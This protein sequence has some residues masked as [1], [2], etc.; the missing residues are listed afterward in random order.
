MRVKELMTRRN[1]GTKAYIEHQG[2]EDCAVVDNDGSST[3][4]SA[5]DLQVVLL[6]F[7]NVE[8][9]QRLARKSQHNT[10]LHNFRVDDDAD[11]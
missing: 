6:H 7:G 4:V 9:L 10:I 11:A 3:G 8:K 1:K 5:N 2:R